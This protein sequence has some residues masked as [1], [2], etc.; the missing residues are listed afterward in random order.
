MSIEVQTAIWRS[1]LASTE[2]L[3]ALALGDWADDEGKGIY[4]SLDRVAW[5]CGL[6]Y[7]TIQRT[8]QLFLEIGVL[9]TVREPNGRRPG[10]YAMCVESLPEKAPYL[11]PDNV[12]GQG[13]AVE[14][15]RTMATDRPDTVASDTSLDPSSD[16][17]EGPPPSA[18]QGG[19]SDSLFPKAS[20]TQDALRK[21]DD[22]FEA[23][24]KIY[25]RKKAPDAARRAYRRAHRAVGAQ[26]LLD[27]AKR[28]AAWAAA[29]G[30]DKQFL[31]Y[32]ATWINAGSWQDELEAAAPEKPGFLKRINFM[33]ARELL[34]EAGLLNASWGERAIFLKKNDIDPKS[35]EQ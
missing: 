16:P 19:Q 12:A 35:L 25:P 27:G 34:R 4:P 3:V 32:P 17:S 2:M 10:E 15:D 13:P 14:D 33:D 8:V 23:W 20:T 31:P 29:Q 5:K 26:V 18:P 1:G 30:K 21:I 9:R 24:Y 11:R 7:R 28:F 6:S 22:D